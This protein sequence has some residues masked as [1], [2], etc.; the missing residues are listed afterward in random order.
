MRTTAR[1]LIDHNPGVRV[2]MLAADGAITK[3]NV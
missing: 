1:G 3:A 2:G